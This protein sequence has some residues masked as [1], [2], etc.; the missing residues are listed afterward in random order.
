LKTTL[1]YI[2]RPGNI[3]VISPEQKPFKTTLITLSF[4]KKNL[5][6]IVIILRFIWELFL[7]LQTKHSMNNWFPSRLYNTNSNII[8]KRSLWNLH[9]IPKFTESKE[10]ID[11]EPPSKQRIQGRRIIIEGKEPNGWNKSILLLC[12]PYWP[13][14]QK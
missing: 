10:Y 11:Q 6:S 7:F 1:H 3:Q 2:P 5:K 8:Y 12:F 13:D 9:S 4:W 14:S